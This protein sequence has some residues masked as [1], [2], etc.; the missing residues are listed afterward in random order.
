VIPS[1]RAN[2][3]QATVPTLLDTHA[4]VWWLTEDARLSSRARSAITRALG[5]HDA[6]VSL[7]SVWEVAKKVEKQHL[8]LDRPLDH[9]LD[10]A[11]APDGLGVWEITR[12]ILTQSCA[13]PQ[14]FHG[15]PADQI[16]VA[17]ARHH[18]A[19]LVTKDQQLRR[20][21]HVHSLW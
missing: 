10:E 12:P 16:L 19:T 2:R 9:W 3:G 1:A 13:L 20:Y 21:P 15:D 6:W 5:K 17:T 18:G 7:I 11:L 14:P 4:W 8:I